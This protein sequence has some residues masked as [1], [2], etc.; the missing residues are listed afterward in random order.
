MKDR[1][2]LEQQ[3]MRAWSVVEDIDM[4]YGVVV[5]KNPSTDEIANALLG[6]KTIYA[7]KFEE[8][9]ETFEDLIRKGDIK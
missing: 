7:M 9:F 4:L 2:T 6:L 8:L 3:I 5:E 1:F